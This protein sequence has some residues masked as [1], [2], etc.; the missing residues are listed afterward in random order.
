MTRCRF[1][2]AAGPGSG[3]R[4]GPRSSA[5][6]GLS[7]RETVKH[8]VGEYVRRMAHTNGME[9]SRSMLQRAC[10]G[11]YHKLS[12]KYLQRYGSEFAGCHNIC[13]K[14]TLAQVQHVVAGLLGRRL[15]YQDLVGGD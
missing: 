13:E 12:A 7:N 3:P 14:D 6:D 1:G 8:S 2:V 10:K 9:S 4:A 11:V 5:Y 15:M